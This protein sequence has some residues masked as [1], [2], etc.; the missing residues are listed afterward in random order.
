MKS[1]RSI[2]RSAAGFGL[3]AVAVAAVL[4]PAEALAQRGGGGGRGGFGGGQIYVAP[5]TRTAREVPTRSID[6]P[7]WD[8]TLGLDADVFTFARLRYDQQRFF[9]N[10]GG[11]GWTTDLPD[12]DLNLSYRLQQMT[13]MRADP[14]ARLIRAD[15]P[16]LDRYPFLFAA[17]PGALTLSENEIA[18]LRKYLLAGGFMLMTDFWGEAEWANC[19]RIFKEIL[20]SHSFVELPLE[21]PL[22]QS[23]F[24]IREK[25][26][27]PN[28]RNGTALEGWDPSQWQTWERSDGQ[29][30]HH[31]VIFDEKGRIMAMALHNSDDSDGW[32][33]E[34]ESDF[35]FHN[36][37]ERMAYP[38]AINILFYIMT[39]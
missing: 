13:A 17:A 21:H 38:L 1:C 4:I 23:V 36:F 32:E 3:I 28:I 27:V 12:S 37:S 8:Y 34:G 19:E 6:T 25:G 15:D 14:F 29:I 30:V 33:R 9:R 5:G 16:E 26:Q 22:Y 11:G 10:A 7:M 39:H 20:P 24:K 35:Y 18:A 31:R 2:R